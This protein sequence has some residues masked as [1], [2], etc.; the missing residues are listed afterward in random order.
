MN[1][2]EV[3]KV[4][5]YSHLLML[6]TTVHHIYGAI[7]YNTPWRFHVVFISIPVII[8]IAISG[9]SIFKKESNR[10]SFW[11][12]VYWSIIL[13]ASIGFFGLFEGIYNHL[14]KDILFYSGVN[15]EVLFQLFP[16]PKYEMPNDFLFEATGVLQAVLAIL[17]IIHFIRLTKS[18]MLRTTLR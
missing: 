18:A 9:R 13:I 5:I 15:R 4:S 2:I 1:K 7:I 6:L 17:L 12:W 11:F 3:T 10:K 16:P 8:I 14:L